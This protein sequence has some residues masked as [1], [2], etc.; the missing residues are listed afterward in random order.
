MITL[1]QAI[2]LFI[3]VWIVIIIF[4]VGGKIYASVVPG[5]MTSDPASRESFDAIVSNIGEMG[6]DGERDVNVF[7]A[8][9]YVLKM[10]KIEGVEECQKDGCIC[11][12]KDSD[13][14]KVIDCKRFE[15]RK[16]EDAQYAGTGNLESVSIKIEDKLVVLS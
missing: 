15:D 11:L 5:R 9:G 3:G 4:G 7:L 10:G 1:K 14:E 8:E 2:L 12:C 16:F 13:C 6:V